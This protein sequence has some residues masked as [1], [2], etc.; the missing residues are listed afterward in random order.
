MQGVANNE[1][2]EHAEFSGNLYGT[3]VQGVRSVGDNGRICI[4]DI[5]MQV[6]DR[7]EDLKRDWIQRNGCC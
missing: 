3:T 5:D 4:L 6:R 2:I 7:K 1:F